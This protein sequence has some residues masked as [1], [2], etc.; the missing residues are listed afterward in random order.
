MYSGDDWHKSQSSHCLFW[1]KFSCFPPVWSD[2]C[3]YSTS[4]RQQLVPYDPI[5]II[6]L[7][8]DAVQSKL[9]IWN[10]LQKSV[11][12]D[13]PLDFVL[14]LAVCQYVSECFLLQLKEN[15]DSIRPLRVSYCQSQSQMT[16]K[17]HRN[18]II[19]ES[20][21]P[22]QN[23]IESHKSLCLLTFFFYSFF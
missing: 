14:H 23:C 13:L 18:N 15:T 21:L 8:P 11:W 5:Q 10:K 6:F 4:T 17:V 7:P 22:S 12:S 3:W 19:S 20:H 2:K 16:D 9:L 1:P